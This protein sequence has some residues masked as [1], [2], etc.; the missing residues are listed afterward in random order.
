MRDGVILVGGGVGD[1]AGRKMHRGLIAVAGARGRGLRAELDRRHSARV[2]EVGL[3]A[4]MG[5]KRGTIG[6]FAARPPRLLPSFVATGRY[7]FPFLQIY[8]RQLAAWGF[9]APARVTHNAPERYNGDRAE[10]GQGE[11][12]VL[13]VPDV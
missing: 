9:P 7:R 13:A 3:H 5:M 8:L 2:G 12:L 1:G 11:I 4:G 6:F 10:G